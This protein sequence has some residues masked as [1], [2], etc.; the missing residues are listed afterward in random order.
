M[1]GVN[2]VCHAGFARWV[3]AVGA[4]RVELSGTQSEEPI[5]E[6]CSRQRIRLLAPAT[7]IYRRGPLL[8]SRFQAQMARE[9]AKTR[10]NVG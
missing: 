10:V 6:S 5:E 4:L 8:G 9:L 1:P 2:L 3:R 7:R